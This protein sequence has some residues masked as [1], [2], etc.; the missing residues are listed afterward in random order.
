MIR[1][2]DGSWGGR[3][4]YAKYTLTSYN[5]NRS[6]GFFGKAVN[7]RCDYYWPGAN[8]G[9]T[10]TK[11]IAGYN[12]VTETYYWCNVTFNYDELAELRTKDVKQ[13]LFEVYASLN[14][15]I[16]IDM[17]KTSN[18]ASMARCDKDGNAI[19]S[20]KLGAWYSTSSNYVSREDSICTFDLTNDTHGNF[21]GVPQYG[22]CWGRNSTYTG[23][24]WTATLINNESML[25]TSKRATLYVITN[26]RQ[27][28]LSFDANGGSDAPASVTGVGVDGIFKT[29]VPTSVPTYSHKVFI[30][31][32]ESADGIGHVYHPGDSITVNGDTTLYAKWD[33]L[34]VRVI[35]LPGEGGTGEYS[36]TMYGGSEI[37]IIDVSCFVKKPGYSIVGYADTDGGLMA[38]SVGDHY[39]LGDEDKTF[40]ACWTTAT[41][42]ISYDANGGEDAPDAQTKTGGTP[43]TLSEDVPKRDGYR[44]LGW[45]L[46]ADGE[47]EYQPG[48]GYAREGDQTLYAVWEEYGG[49]VR[50][51]THDGIKTAKAY[52]MTE[53]GPARAVVYIMTEDGAREG[54]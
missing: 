2:F 47:A 12:N 15:R 52:V 7:N 27:S 43:V 9:T 18:S 21:A 31:W 44:F 45:S 32:T 13:V 3:N 23:G 17:K 29:N 30:G 36:T 11:P 5:E 48:D 16:D 24:A 26:E 25:T 35:Y 20:T 46:S 39:T 22:Y 42:T 19:S 54:I 34:F 8:T 38:Y 37:N 51:A 50:V 33:P 6:S 10:S 28:T 49:A 53:N 1:T 14:S 4:D 40:Y 41:Y